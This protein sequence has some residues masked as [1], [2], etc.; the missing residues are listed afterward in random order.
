MTVAPL[1]AGLKMEGIVKQ[2]CLKLQGPL[3]TAIF[4]NVQK[5]VVFDLSQSVRY[6]KQLM[7]LAYVGK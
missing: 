3:Y 6:S 1:I 7:A 2:N 5:N 4:R